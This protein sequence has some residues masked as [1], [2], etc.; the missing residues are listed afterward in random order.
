[1]N[2]SFEFKMRQKFGN[3]AVEICR[4]YEKPENKIE[5]EEQSSFQ[6]PTTDEIMKERVFR[7]MQCFTIESGITGRQAAANLD[8]PSDATI[9]ACL[10]EL[11]EESLNPN[12]KYF[13]VGAR[14]SNEGRGYFFA[15][16]KSEIE[17]AQAQRA[18]RIIKQIKHF[19]A[20]EV[21]FDEDNG[22]QNI[23]NN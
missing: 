7:A 11:A 21:A 19:F 22:Q 18:S 5:R 2:R 8:L 14:I 6:R 10:E 20:A 9:R 13:K 3:E 23:F 17:G 12:S 1:M 15:R 16:T 4:R